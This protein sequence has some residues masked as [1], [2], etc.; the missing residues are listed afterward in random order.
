MSKFKVGE[1]AIYDRRESPYYGQEVE[2]LSRLKRV[3]I[4]ID[5]VTGETDIECDAY[6][7]SDSS[8]S[9]VRYAEPHELRK[10]KPPQE[11]ASLETLKAITGWSPNKVKVEA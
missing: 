8:I 10:K 1:I 9:W 3:V 7:I 4:G 2:V 5:H 6:Q 11:L